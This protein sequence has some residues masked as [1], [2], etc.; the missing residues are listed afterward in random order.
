MRLLAAAAACV[1]LGCDAA[2]PVQPSPAPAGTPG[3]AITFSLSGIVQDTAFRP[4]AGV[5]VAVVEGARAGVSVTTDVAGRYFLPGQFS[6]AITVEAA[7]DGYV[8]ERKR[9][10]T[11]YP[12]SQNLY[13]TLPPTTP[14]PSLAGEYT[15][16]LTASQACTELPEA[17]RRRTYNASI[18]PRAG[19][20]NGYHVLLSG[21]SF[22]SS[23][24]NDRLFLS[25][26]AD[27][28]RF[29]VDAEWGNVI[30]EELGPSS[31]AVIWGRA[32]ADV[33]GPAI[34]APF[35]GAFEHCTAPR[36]AIFGTYFCGDNQIVCGS[37]N[38]RLALQRR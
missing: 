4:V 13:F 16:T 30:A 20:V 21:A 32:D 25:V 3:G 23:P 26:A 37:A 31:Y 9:Y 2:S 12:G 29:E 33:S 14:S 6:E 22:L 10:E 15:L 34:T 18:V 27:F 7:K 35:R 5:T 19:A 28:G 36:R 1:C 11:R 38:H 8:S 17:A 24:D